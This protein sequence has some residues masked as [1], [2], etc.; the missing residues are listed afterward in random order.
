MV[1]DAKNAAPLRSW[2]Y[3]TSSSE[4]NLETTK[5]TISLFYAF[6]VIEAAITTEISECDLH[7]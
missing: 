1:G 3:I 5:W 6:I 2:K 7:D 4:A